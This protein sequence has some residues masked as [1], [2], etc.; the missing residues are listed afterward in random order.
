MHIK[1]I[2]PIIYTFYSNVIHFVEAKQRESSSSDD[3]RAFDNQA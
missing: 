3:H 2:Y 1:I